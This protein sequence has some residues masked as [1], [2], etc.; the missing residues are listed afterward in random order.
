MAPAAEVVAGAE[1]AVAEPE[2]IKK[3]KAEAGGE[4]GEKAEKPG[5]PEKAEKKEKK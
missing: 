1:G 5:K 2:V 4:E 3:G